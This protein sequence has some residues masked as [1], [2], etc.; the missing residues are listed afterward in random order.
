M[1]WVDKI[2]IRGPE[3]PEGPQGVQGLPGAGAVP[4][5]AAMAGYVG[6]AGESQTRTALDQRYARVLTP[7]QFG[8]VGDGSADDTAALQALLAAVQDGDTI[9]GRADG[10]YRFTTNL[11]LVGKDRW[12]W[13]GGVYL[14]ASLQVGIKGS[15]VAIRLNQC[16]DAWMHDIRVESL[17]QAQQHNG[18]SVENSVGTVLE[19]VVAYSFRWVG[20]GVSG[21]SRDVTLVDC[22]GLR[23][24]VGG[25]LNSTTSGVKI[26]GGR[27]SSEWSKTQEYVDK[28]GVWDP[29]SLYYDGLI[30]GGNEWL[31]DGVTLDDNGQ[32]GVYGGGGNF[33]GVVS[34]C[35]VARNWNKG[36]DFG[37]V[38]A[39]TAENAID[40]LVFSGNSVKGN[41]TGD[42]H[43]SDATRC[44]VIGNRVETTE[45]TFGIGLNGASQGNTILGNRVR[46]TVANAAIFVN[47]TAT[48]NHVLHNPISASTAYS[49]NAA[50]NVLVALTAA[51]VSHRSALIV[52]LAA[53][54][55]FEGR[56]ALSV[57]ASADN[58][59]AQI[60]S[61]MPVRFADGGGVRKQIQVGGVQ[62]TAPIIP[63]GGNTAS[64]PTMASGGD[65]GA[66]YFDLTLGKP[67]FWNGT[68]WKDAAGTTV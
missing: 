44:L 48:G 35:T 5:D 68:V 63:Q 43:L 64:R 52:D 11:N 21:T 59:Y 24:Y 42:I 37:V 12:E 3:G 65:F 57:T 27:Y 7:E 50:V 31:I 22:Q 16:D 29:T 54:A 9:R 45:A 66:F 1:V 40:Q 14:F 28:G 67:I 61:N 23:C 33:G 6:T 58:T 19:R 53:N 51:A 60:A 10:R 30:V 26:R 25:F 47:T 55:G 39:V 20:L 13:S 38:G 32:S 34:N 17:T 8:A 46:S 41:K 2:N 49:V 36:I 18:V 15:V 62:S 56:L 4:A